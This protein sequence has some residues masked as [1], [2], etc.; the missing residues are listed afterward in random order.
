MLKFMIILFLLIKMKITVS[1]YG[2]NDKIGNVS[3]YDSKQSDYNFT[4]PYSDSTAELIDNEVKSLI[5]KAYVRTKKLLKSKSKE[6]E[7]IAKKL[8]EK[9]IIFQNDLETLIGKRPFKH[10]TTFQAFTN[11]KNGKSE[12]K[13]APRKK[14]AK[15]S[16]KST[17]KAAPKRN[18]TKNGATTKKSVSVKGA[19]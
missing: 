2:M 11:D 13:K 6:L 9:E 7:I 10:Q 12:T 16:T 5:E 14:A 3:F 4:K 17:S 8:L 1:I 19:K 15:S 18:E